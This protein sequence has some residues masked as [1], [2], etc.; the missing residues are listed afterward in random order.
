MPSFRQYD[1]EV[2]TARGVV[3]VLEG[4][5]HPQSLTI[6]KFECMERSIAWYNAAEYGPLKQMCPESNLGDVLVVEG[7]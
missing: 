7:M 2:V 4:E 3:I 5:W 6:L 1:G